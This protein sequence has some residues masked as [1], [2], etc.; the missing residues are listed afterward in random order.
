[1]QSFYSNF[2]V[3]VEEP[4]EA[5]P[6]VGYSSGGSRS[7]SC[8]PSRLQADVGRGQQQRSFYH[9]SF[10][11]KP[12]FVPPPIFRA[13]G[14]RS[15]EALAMDRQL[16]SAETL[17][18]LMA[19][20]APCIARF[21]VGNVVIALASCARVVD[22]RTLPTLKFGYPAF[23]ALQAR[24]GE[25]VTALEPRGLAMLA[26]SAAKLGWKDIDVL[27]A[28][29]SCA[30]AKA[31][32]LTSTD[33]AKICWAFSKLDVVEE[34]PSFWRT[35]AESVRAKAC[36]AKSVDLSMLAWAFGNCGQGDAGLCREMAKAALQLMSELTPQCLANIAWA[37]AR[38]AEPHEELFAAIIARSLTSIADFVD[39]DVTHLCWAL[40]KLNCADAELFDMLADHTVN[41]GPLP[42]T[43]SWWHAS[44]LEP[45]HLANCAW[46]FACVEWT[47]PGL[48]GALAH[49]CKGGKLWTFG[50]DEFC[51]IAWAFGK[52]RMADAEIRSDLLVISRQRCDELDNVSFV[53]LL[54][55]LLT[56]VESSGSTHGEAEKPD[57]TWRESARPLVEQLEESLAKRQDLTPQQM[58]A[59]CRSLCRAGFQQV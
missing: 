33:L 1:M 51:A 47:D 12:R 39:F 56:M 16:R 54:T 43:D 19:L 31:P 40:A 17:H 28:V 32:D 8:P 53:N 25:S 21:D 42:E 30:S 45:Q 10:W 59:T 26:H 41:H 44:V 14:K 23:P 5:Q 29:A 55:S 27:T 48:V 58:A 50:P 2:V 4:L 37:M 46:A 7:S 9:D 52:F 15:D 49:A 13:P 22:E 34:L 38:L 3:K 11:A 6:P 24:A 20:V 18:A 36:T 57:R 35:M